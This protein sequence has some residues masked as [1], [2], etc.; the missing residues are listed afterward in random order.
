MPEPLSNNPEL[1]KAIVAGAATMAAAWMSVFAAHEVAGQA[2]GSF[3]SCFN[4]IRDKLR[5]EG[6][7][8]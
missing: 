7:I 8:P 5:E 6:L 3:A 1:Q 2:T 4:I